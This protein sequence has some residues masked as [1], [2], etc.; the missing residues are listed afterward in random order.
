[1][2]PGES[3]AS[4]LLRAAAFA[5]ERHRTQR[6][7]DEEATPYVNHPLQVAELLAVVGEVADPEVLAAAL[8]HDTV[9]D[10]DT[11]FD[12]IEEAFGPAVRAYVA[13]V[14]DDKSLPKLE[15]KRLQIEHASARS[16]EA[17]QIKLADK[18]CNVRDLG[19]RRPAGW[20]PERVTGYF[21]WAEQVI[22]GL[23][24]A[25]PALE[26]CFE[27]TLAASRRAVLQGETT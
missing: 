23:P 3:T 20:P 19:A 13:E 2:K 8:L 11:S 18:I 17:A 24:P 7:K 9:E 10:T 4:F 14:T 22:Q 1:M 6:R 15:R 21:D 5:A 25:N 16:R 12:E 26:T 27:Q